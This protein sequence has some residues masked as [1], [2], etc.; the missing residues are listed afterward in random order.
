M[1]KHE[2]LEGRNNMG[3]DTF[4]G[5]IEDFLGDYDLNFKITVAKKEEQK[6]KIKV[7]DL[8]MS[9]KLS[10]IVSEIY[11]DIIYIT[12]EF[13]RDSQMKYT[14]K[15]VI[16]GLKCGNWKLYKGVSIDNLNI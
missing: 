15:E 2:L 7:G 5:K 12:W 13:H 9:G 11:E 4:Y 6:L 3:D 10:G 8:I 16:G 14:R 1:K